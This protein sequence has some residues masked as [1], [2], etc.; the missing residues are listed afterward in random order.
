MVWFG[1][2]TSSTKLI[3]IITLTPRDNRDPAELDA[4]RARDVNDEDDIPSQLHSA[5]AFLLVVM[6]FALLNPRSNIAILLL[7]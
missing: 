2:A 7:H 3:N 5:R 1:C 6:C 4:A